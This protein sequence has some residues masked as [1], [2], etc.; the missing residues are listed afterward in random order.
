MFFSV[1]TKN[2]NWEIL[3]KN[4]VIFKRWNGLMMKILV[5]LGFTEKSNFQGGVTK[6]QHRGGNCLKRGSWTGCRFKGRFG[7]KERVVFLRGG[8]FNTQRDVKLPNNG[9][10]GHDFRL[11]M[12]LYAFC[13]SSSFQLNLKYCEKDNA[14]F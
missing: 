8:G 3:T 10:K 9:I 7:E 12:K 2:L 11:N 13:P 14:V 1:V 5:S 4:L 6:K